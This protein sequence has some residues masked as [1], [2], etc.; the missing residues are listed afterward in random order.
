MPNSLSLSSIRSDQ[1]VEN[2]IENQKKEIQASQR[3]YILEQM[4][5]QM[6]ADVKEELMDQYGVAIASNSLLNKKDRTTNL[7]LIILKIH[8]SCRK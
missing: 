4:A 7:P 3:A 5:V 2:S 8:F 6:E 1:Q